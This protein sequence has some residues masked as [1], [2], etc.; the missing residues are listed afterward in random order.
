[1]DRMQRGAIA[2]AVLAA[3]SWTLAGASIAD[4]AQSTGKT[5]PEAAEPGGSGGSI[6]PLGKKLDRSGG[7]I[8]PPA[9]IDPGL[10]RTPPQTG[11]TP[12]IPPPGSA[13]DS[14]VKPK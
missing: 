8:E 4:T 5:V 14:N 9:G 11:R 3:L 6:E 2:L 1:M 13:G 10:Q 7:V 12:V